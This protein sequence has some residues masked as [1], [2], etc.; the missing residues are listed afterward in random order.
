[1]PTKAGPSAI[2]RASSD[3]AVVDPRIVSVDI[4]FLDA[5]PP[6]HGFFV[7]VSLEAEQSSAEESPGR[8]VAHRARFQKSCD[9]TPQILLQ[10]GLNVPFNQATRMLNFRH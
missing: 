4:K 2:I 6:D 10:L 8:F 7:E 9:S 1:M 3:Q 5:R